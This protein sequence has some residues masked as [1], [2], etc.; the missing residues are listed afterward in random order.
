LLPIYRTLAFYDREVRSD[1]GELHWEEGWLRSL[2]TIFRR[3]EVVHTAASRK[4]AG[5]IRSQAGLRNIGVLA[6]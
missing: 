1:N 4:L 2:I 3:S 5:A 6:H